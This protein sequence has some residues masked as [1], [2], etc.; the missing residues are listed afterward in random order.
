MSHG[1]ITNKQFLDGLGKF[2]D[3]E[4]ADCVERLNYSYSAVRDS[5]RPRVVRLGTCPHELGRYLSISR[6]S[7]RLFGLSA[8]GSIMPAPLVIFSTFVGFVGGR[9]V[10]AVLMTLGMFIP[11]TSF[12]I[13][14]HKVRMIAC[15]GG[16]V[17]R[18]TSRPVSVK[19]VE[20]VCDSPMALWSL[21]CS[22]WSTWCTATRSAPR[23]RA[24][25]LVSD[26]V[27][28]LSKVS[29]LLFGFHVAPSAARV[30]P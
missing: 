6:Q 1:W 28:N 12:P 21:V 16:W 29:N 19:R 23:S 17:G 26:S 13:L 11:A 27:D 22:S 2:L 10:G 3:V 9:W 14:G 18:K 25:P 8:L 24:S 7:Y 20:C 15:M 30:R 5:M 4:A